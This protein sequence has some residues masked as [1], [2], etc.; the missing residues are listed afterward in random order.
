MAVSGYELTV[1][2]R[3][4]QARHVPI[5][6][7]VDLAKRWLSAQPGIFH[8]W[9]QEEIEG[10]K[11][12]APFAALYRN[13]FDPE[14]SG[15]LIVQPAPTCLFSAYPAGTSHGTP[16]LYD[17]AIPLVFFG[18]GV[19]PGVVRG[20]ATS[21]DIA[22]TLARAIGVEAPAELDGHPLSLEP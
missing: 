16:Y 19:S 8:V 5:P 1:N 9:T 13:S 2:R 10:G 12:P 17:R 6:R 20:R 22:P 15:D 14:R 4:A 11:G 3:L 21:V 18:P 7:A